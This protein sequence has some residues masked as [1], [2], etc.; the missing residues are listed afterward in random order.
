MKEVEPPTGIVRT[1]VPIGVI[2]CVL[3]NQKYG[4]QLEGHVLSTFSH[5]FSL[6]SQAI[7]FLLCHLVA[8][9]F[10][11]VMIFLF[12]DPEFV[13]MLSSVRSDST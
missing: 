7:F 2:P 12:Y 9:F 13:C 11:F 8:I 10:F 1:G 6:P 5:P 4:S 3:K